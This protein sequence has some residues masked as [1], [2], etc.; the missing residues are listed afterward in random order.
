VALPTGA[1]RGWLAC[2]RR[3]EWCLSRMEATVTSR[4]DTTEPGVEEDDA[5]FLLR[6]PDGSSYRV[7]FTDGVLA[8]ENP[9]LAECCYGRR[10][11]IFVSSTVDRLY[12]DRLRAYFSSWFKPNS[13]DVTVI[14]TGE[15][16]KTMESVQQVCAE[17][18]NDGLDRHGVMVA[19]GGG[20]TCDI[21]GFAA[22]IYLRGVPY[23]KVNTT[24]VGQV[25]VG[26]GVKTGVNGMGAKNALGAYHVAHASINDA[27]FLRTLPQ[28]E[29]RCGLGEVVK[30]AVIRDEGLFRV[31]EENPG[32]FHAGTE[33]AAHAQ[34]ALERDV[35]RNA[36][37][38]M[39]RELCHNLREHDLARLVDF[40]HSF[41]PLIET[42]SGYRIA[43]GESVA[44]DM[45]IST[46]IAM[47]LGVVDAADGERI[48]N[49]IASLGLPLFDVGTCTPPA[50][51]NA[52]HA[53]CARRGG[54]LNLV[55]PTGLGSATF[56][57]EL[58]DVPQATVVQALRILSTRTSAEGVSPAAP[59][60]TRSFGMGERCVT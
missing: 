51:Q 8:R 45:A 59:V 46:Q 55:V 20:I 12:G 6:A 13:W 28:R 4:V 34:V 19:V 36:I 2:K 35:I 44:I 41:G 37:G 23:V 40:G 38:L 39:L 49:L 33:G 14:R 31:L 32:L 22:A 27:T 1:T 15:R 57:R 52:L 29:I 58:D 30:M 9:L 3:W 54:R 25:D 11:S 18:K 43:H 10:A 53:S 7:D 21:V 47:L 17:A 60:A 48:L 5:G 50:M 56:L 26:V 42:A 16:N 24:L